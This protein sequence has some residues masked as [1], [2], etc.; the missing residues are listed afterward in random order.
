[1]MPTDVDVA[2][3]LAASHGLKL[4]GGVEFNEMG[5]D[6]RVGFAKDANGQDWVLRIPRRSDAQPKL[7]YEAK[8][9]EFVK[10]RLSVSVPDWRIKSTDLVAYPRLRDPMAL[11]FDAKTHEV[12]WNMDQSSP[13]YVDSLATVLIELHASPEEAEAAGIK[14]YSPDAVRTETLQDLERV[15]QEIGIGPELEVAWRTWLDND[16]LWPGFSTLV[17]GDL[18]AGHIT[19][20]QDS[21]VSGII[22]WTEAHVGDP[23]VDFSGHLAVF[24]PESLTRLLDAYAQAGG[25]TW[26]MM[27]EQIEAR[28]LAAGIRYGIFALQTQNEEHLAAARSMLGLG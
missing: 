17:H 24:G 20:D 9:L 14:S 11:T 10:H 16:P 22:D 4:L 6:Y 7:D 21:C 13:L 3:E 26:P 19:A 18:Y 27:R 25:R 15:K 12:H 23:A 28:S 8:V 1:M 5:L 2:L